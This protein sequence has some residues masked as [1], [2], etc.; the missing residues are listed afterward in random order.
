MGVEYSTYF[1]PIPLVTLAL[2]LTAVSK[3][4]QS[5]VQY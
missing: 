3:V 1:N 4:I 5:R 2:T